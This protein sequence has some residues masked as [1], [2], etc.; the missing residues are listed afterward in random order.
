MKDYDYL[1]VFFVRSADL[2]TALQEHVAIVGIA[3]VL[4][5]AV[6]IPLGIF[7]SKTRVPAIRTVVFTVTN[8]IQTIPS[9]AL[10]AMLIPLLGI[11]IVPAVTALFLYSLMPILRNTYAGFE[12]V[13]PG[14]VQAATGM[15]F[16]PVQRMLKIELP[17]AF[18]YIISGI[19][20]TT[21]YVISWAILAT[22]IGAGGLGQLILGGIT[23]YDKP[24]ILAASIYSMLLALVVDFL[25]GRLARRISSRSHA[26]I[27]SDRTRTTNSNRRLLSR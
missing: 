21:V 16:G 18:P 4:G 24:L 20:L 17:L 14:V 1:T 23:A 3:V 26:P 27:N 13:D 25:L 9:L 12:S 11:G 10:L 7:L 5:G 15:G 22:L 2:L 8:I 6:A 19:R